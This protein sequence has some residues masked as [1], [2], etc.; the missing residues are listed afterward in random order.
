MRHT[1]RTVQC[2]QRLDFAADQNRCNPAPKLFGSF[3]VILN[4]RNR[5]VHLHQIHR[6]LEATPRMNGSR[7]VFG[8]VAPRQFGKGIRCLQSE[9]IIA[10]SALSSSESHAIAKT[11]CVSKPS[12][13]TEYCCSSVG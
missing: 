3:G 11:D 8:E 2:S 6:T 1:R 9:K 13:E 5:A 7:G 4:R 10:E 12:C